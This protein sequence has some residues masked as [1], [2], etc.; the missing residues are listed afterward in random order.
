V[1]RCRIVQEYDRFTPQVRI[2]LWLSDVFE[3]PRSFLT[4]EEAESA[5]R[6]QAGRWNAPRGVAKTL[7][8]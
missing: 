2:L 3:L 5:L 7:S 8:V 4:L 1:R 6:K